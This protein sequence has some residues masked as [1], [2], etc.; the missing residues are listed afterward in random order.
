MS[1]VAIVVAAA[2]VLLGLP[3][4]HAMS[5]I[6]AMDRGANATCTSDCRSGPPINTCLTVCVAAVAVLASVGPLRRSLIAGRASARSLLFV[7]QLSGSSLFRPPR[8][9]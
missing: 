9:A 2:V 3:S 8:T 5:G 4:A 7:E 1:R 6:G